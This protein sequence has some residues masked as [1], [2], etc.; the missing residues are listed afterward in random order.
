[1]PD[2][3][4]FFTALLAVLALAA[5]VVMAILWQAERGRS[6]ARMER[7][8]G[9]REAALEEARRQ[10]V[11]RSR[12]TLKGQIAEQMA[13][14][15]PGFAYAPADARFMGDPIDYVVFNGYTGVRD[16]RAG[17]DDLEIVLLEVKQGSSSL[18]ASQ[19]AVARAVREGRVR[20]ELLRIGDDGALST[21][22]WRPR[23]PGEAR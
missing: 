10:S 4:V 3:A 19:R 9:E 7:M 5:L 15:L 6:Q 22:E 14:L 20:F 21:E 2:P 16:D 1:M 18:S 12:S 8:I 11:Q 13:P 23:R 17:P